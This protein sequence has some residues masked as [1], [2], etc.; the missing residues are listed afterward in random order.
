[1]T[2][3]ILNLVTLRFSK[4]MILD[5]PIIA[6]DFDGTL[7][8]GD[9]RKWKDGKSYNDILRPRKRLFRFLLKNRDKFYLI[10]WSC[11][12]GA[13]MDRAIVFCQRNGLLFD[14]INDNLAPYPTERKILADYYLDDKAIKPNNISDVL[15]NQRP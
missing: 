10:L 4:N 6:V 8:L 12:E 9:T 1:M 5:K 11:R 13:D 3:Y 15:R 2:A 7:T 14:K